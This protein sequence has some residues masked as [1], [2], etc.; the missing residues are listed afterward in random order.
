[1]SLLHADIRLSVC[2]LGASLA[3]GQVLLLD[4]FNGSALD[5]TLWR[6]PDPGAGSFL[7]RTQ[8]RLQDAPQVTGGV[9]RLRLDTW[10][11]GGSFLGSEII[12]T[13]TFELGT[14]LAFETTSRLVD[15]P[16]GLVGSLFSYVFFS[17]VRDEIDVELLS[18]QV[19][20]GQ[21]DLLTNVFDNDGFDTGGDGAFVD[22][23]GLDLT[24]FNTYRV[25]WRSDRIDWFV[26]G[27]LVRSETHT[28]PDA[29]TTIRLNFWAPGEDFSAAYSEQLQ[30]AAFSWQ[31][32]TYYYEV[33][34][35]LIERL[36]VPE[37]AMAALLLTVAPLLM[38][39]RG[40]AD[41]CADFRG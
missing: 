24:R 25:E 27:V 36:S 30:P 10:N 31:N 6:L 16:P 32:Q 11:G 7:G 37:P 4:E 40:G 39:R 33:D 21:H 35:V 8:L 34:R 41:G 1:M 23:A 17:G 14:G 2:L 20:S 9:A 3:H 19:H 13:Q 12:T 28:V 5:T 38:R 15:P 29:A 18:N 26:N 22:P